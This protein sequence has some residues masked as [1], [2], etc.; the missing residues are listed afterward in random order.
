MFFQFQQ[1][2]FGQSGCIWW[3][4][5]VGGIL[6]NLPSSR[7]SDTI[8]AS[9][10]STGVDSIVARGL[11]LK[12]FPLL[13]SLRSPPHLSLF[14]LWEIYEFVFGFVWGYLPQYF[15]SEDT[16]SESYLF[17]LKSC[18]LPMRLCFPNRRQ[19]DL[20]F[21]VFTLHTFFSMLSV[22]DSGGLVVV[23]LLSQ[24]HKPMSLQSF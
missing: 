11:G 6:I 19:F 3:P 22:P 5:G 24:P 10:P 9:S 16:I 2:C 20:L 4:I 15:F 14:L 12:R 8:Y 17:R 13:I 1:Y 21:R 7:W 18:F 23:S